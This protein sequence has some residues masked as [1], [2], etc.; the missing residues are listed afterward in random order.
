MAPA[1]DVVRFGFGS[2]AAL[3]ATLVMT[4]PLIRGP[5]PGQDQT[6]C[7]GLGPAE[8]SAGSLGRTFPGISW[9]QWNGKF[10]DCV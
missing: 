1:G 9:L 4:F 2:L 10:R 3:L 6:Y 7:R 8:L 5:G